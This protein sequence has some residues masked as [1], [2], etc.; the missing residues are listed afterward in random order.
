MT[1]AGIVLVALV[2]LLTVTLAAGA[3]Y[4]GFHR[5]ARRL[6]SS[7]GHPPRHTF[8]EMFF[9]LRARSLSSLLLT[10]QRAESPRPAEHPMGSRVAV[11]WMNAIGFN[12]GTF[13]APPLGSQGQMDLSVAIGPH[14]GKPLV[15][16]MP[17]LIAPMGYGIGLAAETKAA[18]AQAATLAGI[19]VV[20][21]E[22]A[23]IPE[24]RAYAAK[25][26]LQESRGKWAHQS[27]VRGL[28]DMI[29]I[30]WGQ[31]SEGGATV[32]KP[33]VEIPLRMARAAKGKAVIGAAPRDFA[34]WAAAIKKVRPDCPL[35]VKIPASQH[36]EEDL[37]YLAAL[38][39]DVVT[40]DGSGAGSTGSPA[41]ISD[42]FG[43]SAV[44][45]CHRAHQWLTM[46]GIRSRITL[47]ISGGIRDA[48]D[49]V[50]LY[51]LGADAVMVGTDPLMAALHGQVSEW[52]TPVPPTNLA[53][54]RSTV[55]PAPPLDVGLAAE[56]VWN[57]LE[58]TRSEIKTI[59]RTMG[60]SSLDMLR[61]ERPLVGRTREAAALFQI[62]FDAEPSMQM[63][64]RV[65]ELVAQYQQL[66]HTLSRIYHALENGTGPGAQ[67]RA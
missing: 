38:P 54:A 6:E 53:F 5:A 25:W 13:A 48:A 2:P 47:I 21:G 51:A 27:A 1:T 56:H 62:P 7:M 17:V 66:N 65:P 34:G 60:M 22:G 37:A 29:E 43:I 15:L 3:C 12:P 9:T 59:L 35:G 41:A 19:A 10:L 40:L 52:W 28:A 24:E 4:L 44:L 49:T 31:A 58:A 45:A 33:A 11:D 36:V 32:V 16:S 57:W 63:G 42:H 23:F 14:C 55:N 67:P 30:Q 8:W 39:V 61:S 26:V 50:R 46:A 64:Q 18:L 20:S